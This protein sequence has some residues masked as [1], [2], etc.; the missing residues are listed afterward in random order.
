MGT[1]QGGS[2]AFMTPGLRMQ[3][4]DWLY[5]ETEKL[6][7]DCETAA[8][9]LNFLERYLSLQKV[10]KQE[11]LLAM[12]S[13]FSLSM[14][15]HNSARVIMQPSDDPHEPTP[16]DVNMMEAHILETINWRVH[17]VTSYAIARNAL[18]VLPPCRAALKH[19]RQE[20]VDMLLYAAN[21]HYY[22]LCETP[23]TLAFAAV[24]AS[25]FYSDLSVQSVWDLIKHLGASVSDCRVKIISEEM[26]KLLTMYDNDPPAA[27]LLDRKINAGSPTG[28]EDLYSNNLSPIGK[29][30]KELPI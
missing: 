7:L 5:E 22:L 24:L 28:V 25:T 27:P 11:L 21:G 17:P 30:E 10:N 12:H 16:K 29:G 26:L 18:R 6:G 2:G 8:I 3:Y 19:Q 9:A 14:R 1:I 20:D 4:C 13:S 23:S 15:V